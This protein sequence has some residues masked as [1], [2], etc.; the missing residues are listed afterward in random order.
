[1]NRSGLIITLLMG[2]LAVLLWKV[3][4]APNMEPPWPAKIQGFSFSPFR[5]GQS[6]STHTFPSVEEIDQDL[7]LL[8]GDVHAVRTYSVDQGLDQVVPIAEKHGLKV[9]LGI[10]I[11]RDD[12]VNEVQI[13]DAIKLA[14]AHRKTIKAIKA[15]PRSNN[16]LPK[17][18]AGCELSGVSFR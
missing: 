3:V 12:K 5:A 13:A 4:N 2:C 15:S 10:W 16:S 14:K 8:A 17:A 11:G 1:M 6:P 18:A 9:L 7:A